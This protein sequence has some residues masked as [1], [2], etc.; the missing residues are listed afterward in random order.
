VYDVYLIIR[1]H[2][3]L[4]WDT[5]EHQAQ[6][7]HYLQNPMQMDVGTVPPGAKEVLWLEPGYYQIDIRTR[8]AKYTE[9]IKFGVYENRPGQSYV[10][11]DYRGNT[12]E[13]QTSP[14]GFPKIYNE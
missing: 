7:L 1:S 13:K 12:F 2:V 4:P 6:A 9:M 5:P 10:I 14:D 8:Y 3:D 11:S